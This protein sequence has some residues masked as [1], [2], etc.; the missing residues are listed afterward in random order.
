MDK[1]IYKLEPKFRTN[2]KTPEASVIWVTGRVAKARTVIGVNA[3]PTPKPC[4]AL[5]QNTS[6]LVRLRFS[7]AICQAAKDCAVSPNATVRRGQRRL[8]GTTTRNATQLPMRRAASDSPIALS[9]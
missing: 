7:C 4:N 9:G 3:S 5:V 8:L 6:K 2:V 1:E